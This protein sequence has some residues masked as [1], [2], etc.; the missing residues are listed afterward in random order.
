MAYTVAL[1][2]HSW[3]RWVVF[4]LAI[5]TLV[6]SLR[7]WRAGAEWS[8]TDKKVARGLVGAVDVQML[9]GLA[10]LC[11]LSPFTTAAMHDMKATMK[12]AV[13]RFFTVEHPFTMVLAVIAAHV[14]LVLAKKAKTGTQ[15]HKRMAIGVI[16]MVVCVLIGMPWSWLAH[17]RPLF[18]F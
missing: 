14:G 4:G 3:W 8:A 5:A 12:D 13:L 6:R 17:G 1:F 18:R 10:M 16:V 15:A 2:L 11:F 9:V 7:G